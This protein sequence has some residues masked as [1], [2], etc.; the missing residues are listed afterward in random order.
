MYRMVYNVL[1]Q[2]LVLTLPLQPMG[3]GKKAMEVTYGEHTSWENTRHGSAYNMLLPRSLQW[4][5][6][7]ASAITISRQALLAR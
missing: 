3:A 2:K 1:A 7:C 6:A 5:G 4:Q